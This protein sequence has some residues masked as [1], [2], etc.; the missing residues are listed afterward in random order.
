MRRRYLCSYFKEKWQQLMNF[1]KIFSRRVLQDPKLNLILPCHVTLYVVIR[2]YIFNVATLDFI[3]MHRRRYVN[4][5]RMI[6]MHV[7]STLQ[8]S[9]F[10]DVTLRGRN[11]T[12]IA[13]CSR[14]GSMRSGSRDRDERLDVRLVSGTCLQYVF[15]LLFSLCALQLDI[16]L[17]LTMEFNFLD[18][19]WKRL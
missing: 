2:G 8:C 19:R 11:E 6:E 7:P 13:A 14:Q 15:V 4:I 17:D 1:K 5:K 12:V 10:C 18:V 3:R 9:T 16:S